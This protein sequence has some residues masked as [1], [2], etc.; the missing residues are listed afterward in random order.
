MQG[1]RLRAAWPDRLRRHRAAALFFAVSGSN[2]RREVWRS[3]I[4]RQMPQTDRC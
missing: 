4:R 1:E 2:A 3:V